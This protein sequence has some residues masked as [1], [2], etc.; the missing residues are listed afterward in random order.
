MSK[1][2][3]L[4][5]LVVFVTTAGAQVEEKSNLGWVGYRHDG[6]NLLSFGVGHDFG[7]GLWTFTGANLGEYGEWS[8]FEVAFLV[9]P[10]GKFLI[11][12]IAG[13]TVDWVENPPVSELT[14][15]AGAAG[16]LASYQF[17]ESA[18]LWGYAK[19]KFSW[20]EDD[21]YRDGTAIGGGLFYLF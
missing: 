18:G 1:L 8:I 21:L 7:G 3:I 2:L 5:V 9:S 6:G 10:F 20:K 15:I 17:S 13:P 16:G 4:C 12:P 14:Y 19:Y 11:G